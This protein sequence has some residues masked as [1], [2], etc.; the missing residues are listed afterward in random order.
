[1]TPQQC[2]NCL[3]LV[4][5]AFASNQLRPHAV[6][7]VLYTVVTM[8]V[9]VVHVKRKVKERA[10]VEIAA[11]SPITVIISKNCSQYQGCHHYYICMGL[12][13]VYHS[14]Q[15]LVRG[16]ISLSSRFQH[17]KGKR[18]LGEGGA[19]LRCCHRHCRC[20]HHHYVHWGRVIRCCACRC[21][22]LRVTPCSGLVSR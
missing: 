5:R 17:V 16:M 3:C 9:F 1:M 2:Q 6:S 20:C 10:A 12:V 13:E 19:Y 22:L 15:C 14:S 4:V 7:V 18:G 11:I 8:L 21:R